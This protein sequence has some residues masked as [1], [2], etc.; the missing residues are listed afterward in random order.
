MQPYTKNKHPFIKTINKNNLT[1]IETAQIQYQNTGNH[2]P[3]DCADVLPYK[4]LIALFSKK[5][6]VICQLTGFMLLFFGLLFLLNFAHATE[7][8]LSL[9]RLLAKAASVYNKIRADMRL[10]QNACF[11]D[12]NHVYE[13]PI[14]QNSVFSDLDRWIHGESHRKSLQLARDFLQFLQKD[15]A[16]QAALQNFLSFDVI[17]VSLCEGMTERLSCCVTLCD[18]IQRMWDWV[19]KRNCAAQALHTATTD[20]AYA[21]WVQKDNAAADCIKKLL[22]LINRQYCYSKDDTF[23]YAVL[24]L[25]ATGMSSVDH[26]PKNHEFKEEYLNDNL[27]DLQEAAYTQ[28]SNTLLA[29]WSHDAYG[30]HFQIAYDELTRRKKREEYLKDGYILLPEAL[31][32]E[33]S[34]ESWNNLIIWEDGDYAILLRED[35]QALLKRALGSEASDISWEDLRQSTP[36]K[37]ITMMQTLEKDADVICD[38]LEELQDTIEDFLSTKHALTRPEVARRVY[39]WGAKQGW[40]A[41]ASAEALVPPLERRP[42]NSR[43]MPKS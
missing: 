15:P 41:F 29:W 12:L 2:C 1:T 38:A 39:C 14:A 35:H 25:V 10:A 30:G 31:R 23:C 34:K 22:V 20:Y 42:G 6:M 40:G 8:D 37:F 32:K 26:P 28:L 33:T 18:E 21:C 9:D 13:D 5:I 19:D 27:N 7:A 17:K 11:R 16:V 4:R 36:K 24:R 43:A 3:F